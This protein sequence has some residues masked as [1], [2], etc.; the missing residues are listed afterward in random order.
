MDIANSLIQSQTFGS[1]PMYL[2]KQNNYGK[3]CC[4]LSKAEFALLE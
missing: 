1:Q 4:E 2:Q 3:V